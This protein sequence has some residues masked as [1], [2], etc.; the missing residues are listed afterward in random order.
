MGVSKSPF[1]LPSENY[2]F[3]PFFWFI[4]KNNCFSST[5][6]KVAAKHYEVFDAYYKMVNSIEAAEECGE[7][8]IVIFFLQVDPKNLG[9]VEAFAAA[10]FL[11]K[12]GLSDVVLSRIW[13]LS[14]PAG[15]GYLDKTGMFVALKLVALA[16][17]GHDINM[18][19]IFVETNAP[20]V[21]SS[22]ETS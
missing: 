3:N 5:K 6:F 16:Q 7:L 17:A 14:D 12:S 11:K 21:V 19:N 4:N 22:V 1:F 20:R 13:D 8:K 15:R 18:R 9:T 10:K 2:R